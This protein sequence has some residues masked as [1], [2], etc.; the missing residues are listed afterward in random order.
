MLKFPAAIQSA[1]HASDTIP[2]FTEHDRPPYT[3]RLEI[4]C[5]KYDVLRRTGFAVIPVLV[6]RRGAGVLQCTGM[7]C[8]YDGDAISVYGVELP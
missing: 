7:L 5:S 1:P 2:G 8:A 6:Q 3:R 4:A